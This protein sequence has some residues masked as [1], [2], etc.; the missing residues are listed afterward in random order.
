MADNTSTIAGLFMTP[1]MYQ[2]QRD[3]AALDRFAS[4]A[5]MDPMAQARTSLMY[6]GYQAGNALAGALGV[7]DPMLAQLSQQKQMLANVDFTNAQSLAEAAKQATAAGR[8]DIAQQLAQQAINIQARIDEKQAARAQ[9]QAQFEATLAQRRDLAQEA[10]QTRLLIAQMTKAMA[11]AN[12]DLQRQILQEKLDALKDKAKGI[13]EARVTKLQN[14]VDVADNVIQEAEA[15][16]KLVGGLTTGLTGTLIGL[17]PGSDAYNLQAKIDTI[18]SQLGFSQLQ[19]MRDASPTGGALG[20][21][22]NQE[23]KFLQAALANLDKG[24]DAATLKKNL[25]KVIL[26]YNNWREAAVGKLNEKGV[27]TPS[28]NDPLGLRKP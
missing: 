4:M 8:P 13:E 3:T 15:A 27:S 10:N 1:E 22:S 21:V 14:S 23:I 28:N 12:S 2:Q 20:P 5:Q 6:G 26:H 24:Q 7:Q 17:K 25:D 18:K 16:K 9:Q 11:G 19:A